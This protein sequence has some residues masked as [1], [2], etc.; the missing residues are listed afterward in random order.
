MN[1]INIVRSLIEFRE[2]VESALPNR[3]NVLMNTIDAI[4]IGAGSA[5]PV[6]LTASPVWQYQWESVYSGIRF[7]KED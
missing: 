4:T 1:T 5:T 6:E 2:K 7:A 3:S